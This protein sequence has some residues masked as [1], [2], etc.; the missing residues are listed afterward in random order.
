MWTNRH[1]GMKRNR[2]YEV[3]VLK[4][5]Q[6]FSPRY[7]PQPNSFVHRRRQ[8]KVILTTAKHTYDFLLVFYSNYVP[9]LY[10]F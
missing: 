3:N 7:V 4:T 9:N 1:L 5:A 10:S 6:A 8:Y 2:R